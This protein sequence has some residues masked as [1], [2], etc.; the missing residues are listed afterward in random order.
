MRFRGHEKRCHHCTK[1][2][3]FSWNS[4]FKGWLWMNKRTN[5]TSHSSFANSCCFRFNIL[6]IL[7]LASINSAAGGSTFVVTP[8]NLAAELFA[9]YIKLR[10]TTNVKTVTSIIKAL[11]FNFSIVA[12]P[13]YLVMH[14]TRLLWRTKHHV[15]IYDAN[16]K[17][18][19]S[20]CAVWSDQCFSLFA[21]FIMR[22]FQDGL[23]ANMLIA[24]TMLKYR[25]SQQAAQEAYTTPKHTEQYADC[26]Y[27]DWE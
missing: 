7:F 5:L 1:V 20:D 16:S 9:L 24:N 14:G 23:T 25:R 11:L 21:T 27:V 12:P 10:K 26:E 19:W 3:L 18:H 13:F 22:I 8:R 4:S 17:R 6:D 2:N 15:H